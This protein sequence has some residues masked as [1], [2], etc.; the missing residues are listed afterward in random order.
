[1]KQPTIDIHNIDLPLA[2]IIREALHD[3]TAQQKAT[4]L[5]GEYENDFV[6]HRVDLYLQAWEDAI[7][8]GYDELGAKEIA[9]AEC[10]TGITSSDGDIFKA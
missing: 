5:A 1:M 6:S 4:L 9:L 2:A 10:L 8:A 7:Q 3:L